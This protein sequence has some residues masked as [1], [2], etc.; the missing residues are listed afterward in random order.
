M[1]IL[2][3]TLSCWEAF[4]QIFEMWELKLSIKPKATPRSL[5]ST[6]HLMILPSKL[7]DI[8]SSWIFL[9]TAMAWNLSVWVCIWLSLNHVLTRMLYILDYDS[10]CLMSL[11]Q[12]FQ[13]YCIGQV[14][15]IELNGPRIV[16]LNCH[17]TSSC[18]LNT[19]AYKC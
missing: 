4:L 9:P 18:E 3:K 6:S 8:F 10:R 1:P 11:P 12:T 13:S 17:Q 15:F 16:S 7:K 2:F 14:L 5:T 19:F